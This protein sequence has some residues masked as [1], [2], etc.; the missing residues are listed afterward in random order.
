MLLGINFSPFVLEIIQCQEKNLM[1]KAHL[2]W[3]RRTASLTCRLEHPAVALAVPLGEGL[4][5]PVD[6]LC[7]PG[8]PKAPQEL[9]E[10]EDGMGSGLGKTVHLWTAE[11]PMILSVS[12]YREMCWASVFCYSNTTQRQSSPCHHYFHWRK[13]AYK[14]WE[15]RIFYFKK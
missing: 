10:G 8:E 2:C 13:S 6:L 1:R 9:P 15:I 11:L 3:D 4:H 5:H 12:G 7:L 14:K